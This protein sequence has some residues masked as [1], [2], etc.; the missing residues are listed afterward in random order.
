MSDVTAYAAMTREA[1]WGDYGSI[2]VHGLSAHL[3]RLEGQLQLERTGPYVPGIT[4]P[5]I[6]D[7]VV[8]DEVRER[9]QA[10]SLSGCRFVPLMKSRIVHLDWSDWDLESELPR[11]MP[12]SGEP[13]D[14]VLARSHD[15]ALSDEIGPLW[16][17]QLDAGPRVART[18]SSLGRFQ[19]DFTYGASAGSLPDFWRG[20]NMR[21]VFVS[22]HARE[23]IGNDQLRW[24]RMHPAVPA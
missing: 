21:Y 2:I 16:E 5:G 11:E 20:A 15:H 1:P 3:D 10:A 17:L 24:C 13:E 18:R 22:D 9:I 19:Y 8:V 4:L 7:V 23:V 6:S 12:E 14:F